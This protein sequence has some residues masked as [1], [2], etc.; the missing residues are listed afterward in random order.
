MKPAGRIQAFASTALAFVMVAGFAVAQSYPTRAR[1]SAAAVAS[2]WTTDGTTAS[3]TGNVTIAGILGDQLVLQV[4]SSTA[5]HG[6]TIKSYANSSLINAIEFRVPGSSTLHGYFYADST[7]SA[8]VTGAF[9]SESTKVRG[10]I[11]LAAGTGT[12]TVLSGAVC[13]CTD[14][15]ANA[16]VK[17]AVAT[18]TLT[19]TGT[20]TDVIAYHCL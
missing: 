6:G 18:T 10:T 15:T 4:G 3:T 9:K 14:T 13:V 7:L 12:A 16:S 2:G 5:N 1:L 11:T 8:L 17:C 19:A 20:G